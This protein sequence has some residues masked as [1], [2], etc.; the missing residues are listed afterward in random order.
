MGLY[1]F[2][3]DLMPTLPLP[4]FDYEEI[5]H[6]PFNNL[7]LNYQCKAL[8]SYQIKIRRL[9]FSQ[10]AS[11]Q[12]AKPF[13]SANSKSHNLVDRLFG[14]PENRSLSNRRPKI[15]SNSCIKKRPSPH[16]RQITSQ[17]ASQEQEKEQ[18]HSKNSDNNYH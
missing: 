5:F 17:K 11:E 12:K 7:K 15:F 13:I 18:P 16:H 8:N 10:K 1:H 4:L 3:L 2:P 9:N 14:R 6:D